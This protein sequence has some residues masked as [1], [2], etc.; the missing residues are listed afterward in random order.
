ME[1]KKCAMC[2]QVKKLCE[3]HI[4]P[5]FFGNYI[6]KNSPSGGLRNPNNVNK[7]E[8]DIYK[9]NLLCDECEEIFSKL[10]TYFQNNIFSIVGVKLN[11][12]EKLLRIDTNFENNKKLLK[13][14]SEKKINNIIVTQEIFDFVVSIFYR[15][16]ICSSFDESDWSDEEKKLLN[17]FRKKG[18]EYFLGN[19]K[20][21][22]NGK[23]YLI[24]S[25]KILE[26]IENHVNE[27]FAIEALYTGTCMR[28]QLLPEN[29]EDK[30]EEKYA[31]ITI[32]VPHFIMV[33]E[34]YPNEKIDVPSS[35]ELKIGNIIFKK[36]SC[37]SEHLINYIFN[38]VKEDLEKGRANLSDNQILNILK[39]V[40][41]I[42]DKDIG[43]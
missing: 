22:F 39:R 29:I 24:N 18:K 6:K 14:Y 16:S 35:E 17:N 1:E 36:N 3:S 4:I 12:K 10:E 8:Q 31:K 15:Y 43:N 25:K 26:S 27:N 28:V 19:K 5:K 38:R 21:E 2:G 7:R 13:K 32:I 41:N 42:S 37:I 33:Y 11:D 9:E 20:I 23:F 40:E 30:N 34:L